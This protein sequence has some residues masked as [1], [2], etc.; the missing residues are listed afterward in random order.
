[1]SDLHIVIGGGTIGRRVARMLTE[2]GKWVIVVSR[3]TPNLGLPG[4]EEKIADASSLESLL[5]VASSAKVIYNCANPPY[6]SWVVEWPKISSSVSEFAMRT[7]ADLVICSNLYGYGPHEGVLTEDFPLKAT[8]ANGVARA[9]VWQENKALNDAEK[10]RV[11]EVR[12][13]DYICAN[14]Q[15]RMGDRVV[16]NLIAGKPIQLL[17]AIDQPHTWTDPDDVAKLMLTLA[18]D[19]R[20]WGRPWH[21]PSNEP[22]T[23]REVVADIAKELGVTDY[24]VAPVGI[25]LESILGVFNPVIRELNRGRYQFAKPYVVSS[26]AAQETFGL[27]P[28]PWNQVI[29]DLVMSYKTDNQK[30]TDKQ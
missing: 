19:N 17:G 11:T 27:S 12:G 13:S 25:L 23:Q 22:K 29:A 28:K 24:K 16:P 15:S 21:V 1:M 26:K 7:G 8:W 20:S 9:K 14:E 4:V 10:L 6:N 5:T 30:G 2:K 3:S 18:E